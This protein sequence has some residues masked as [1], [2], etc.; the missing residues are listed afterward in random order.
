LTDGL[1]LIDYSRKRC[2]AVQKIMANIDQ[3]VLTSIRLFEPTI[4]GSGS[5]EVVVNGRI[6]ML[7][8]VLGQEK[9]THAVGHAASAAKVI[10][11]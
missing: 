3:S 9:S 5:A 10:D 11:T 4:P 6:V 8:F 2:E 7:E 1:H